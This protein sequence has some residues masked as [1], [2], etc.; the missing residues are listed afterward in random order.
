M[1]SMAQAGI[2]LGIATR[3]TAVQGFT[4]LTQAMVA[5]QA[6]ADQALHYA[7]LLQFGFEHQRGSVSDFTNALSQVT[8]EASRFHVSLG[9]VIAA[10]DTFGPAMASSSR[11]GTALRYMMDGLYSPTAG[12]QAEMVKLG[13]ASVDAG[14]HFHSAFYNNRGAPIDFAAAVQLLGT[15]LKGMNQEAQNDALHKLFSVKGGQGASDLLNMIQKLDIYLNQLKNSSDNAGGAMARWQQVMGTFAGAMAGLKSSV[16]DLAVVIGGQLLPILTDI[17]TRANGFITAIRNMASANPVATSSFL[18]LGLAMSGVGLV[19]T[20]VILAIAGIGTG[21]LAFIGIVAGVVAGVVLL[22]A[23]IALLA[24]WFHN[25]YSASAPIQAVVGALGAVFRELGAYI[26]GALVG[27][28]ASLRSSFAM[29][30]PAIVELGAALRPLL[31][32]LGLLAAVIVGI[33]IGALFGLVGALRMVI[34]G[35]AMM[36]GGLINIVSGIIQIFTGFLNVIVGLVM[37]NSKQVQE[38]FHQM[39]QGVMRIIQGAFMVV[40]GLVAATLGAVIAFVIGFVTGIISWFTHLASALVGGS[41]IPD[42]LN[43]IRNAFI[44]ILSGIV[45]W[46]GGWVNSIISFFARMGSQVVSAVTA[47][48]NFVRSVITI[49]LAAVVAVVSAGFAMVVSRV[50]SAGSS[51]VSAVSSAWNSVRSF[52]ASAAAS[53]ISTVLSMGASV[54]SAVSSAFNTA[55]SVAAGVLAS[56]VGTVSSGF[57]SIVARVVSAGASII[58]TATS[59]WAGFR[60]ATASGI[61]SAVSTVQGGISSIIGVISGLP[62]QLFSWGARAMQSFASGLKSALG[63]VVGAVESAASSVSNFLGHLSPAKMGP[64]ADDDKWMPNMMNMFASQIESHAPLLQNAVSKAAAGMAAVPQM[65]RLGAPAIAGGGIG[66]GGGGG[67]GGTYTV[68]LVVDGRVLSQVVMNNLGGQLQLN[69][70]GRAFR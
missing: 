1:A 22:A 52:I 45:G 56:I 58:S 16:T 41:I 69:G 29:T 30:W 37:G 26:G 12:A 8:P 35:L 2:A 9:E 13:L 18:T 4:L 49:A 66:V 65:T 57:A 43:A 39:G 36:I 53:I 47:A 19:A 15:K 11:A 61:A 50:L 48:W 6:P 28:L 62:G 10:L 55:R 60:N 63:A 32:I 70:A 34:V 3:S 5:Y 14:G 68:Q 40:V 27:V 51:I 24:N 42:M 59:A 46:I 7:N 67:G 33:V 64:L 17:A 23:V 21:I 44:S 54:V 31:P 25:L 38:G 20:I